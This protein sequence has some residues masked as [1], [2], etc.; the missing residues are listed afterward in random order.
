MA[1]KE[2]SNTIRVRATKLGSFNG[3]RRVGAE[4]EIPEELF[5]EKWMEKVAV[6]TKPEGDDDTP[7]KGSSKKAPKE[8][9]VDAND[10][11]TASAGLV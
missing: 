2:G 4:F 8:D 6:K 5:S 7:K 9:K 10:A 1:K 3:R 11:G